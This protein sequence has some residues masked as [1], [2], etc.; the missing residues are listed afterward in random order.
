MTEDDAYTVMGPLSI[1]FQFSEDQFAMWMGFMRQLG[2][3]A[4]AARAAESMMKEAG[5]TFVPGWDAFQQAYDRWAR[6]AADEEAA[7]RLEIESGDY[8]RQR[9]PSFE[10]GVEIAWRSYC[11]ERDRLGLPHNRGYFDS[12]LS[13]A[14]RAER[15]MTASATRQRR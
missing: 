6:R 4:V 5:S 15:R 12:I 2:S 8:S 9:F 1:A 7:S 11:S 14:L 13:P 3:P 10:E